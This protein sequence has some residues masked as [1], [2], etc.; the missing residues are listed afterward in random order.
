MFSLQ[1][2]TA[3]V[4]GGGSGIGKAVAIVLA[5]QGATIFVADLN[6]ENAAAAADEIIK[7][8][9]AA[10]AVIL[11]VANQVEVLDAF[12]KVGKLDILVNCAGISHIGNAENT[13]EADFD[14][15]YNVNVKGT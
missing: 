4:T 5:K 15:L 13:T 12:L 2:K 6:K 8:G 10:E 3:I 1:N 9:G 11:N 14:K 7:D